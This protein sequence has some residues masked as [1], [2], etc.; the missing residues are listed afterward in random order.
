MQ[1]C[2]DLKIAEVVGV[3][4]DSLKHDRAYSA[5]EIRRKNV[6]DNEMLYSIIRDGIL[7]LH[8][9]KYDTVSI[10]YLD[11]ITSKMYLE[12]DHLFWKYASAKNLFWVEV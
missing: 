7:I 2:T 4:D 12:N 10:I 9:S 11:V 6:W 3:F 8:N 1:I 5:C